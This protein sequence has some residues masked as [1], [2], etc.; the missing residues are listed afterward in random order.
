MEKASYT[1]EILFHQPMVE[2][3]YDKSPCN[4]MN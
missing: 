3:D 1:S 2:L 4:S